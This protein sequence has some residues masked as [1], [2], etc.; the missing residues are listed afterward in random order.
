MLTII[1]SSPKEILE[2]YMAPGIVELNPTLNLNL[3]EPETGYESKKKMSNSIISSHNFIGYI[4]FLSFALVL[5]CF[6]SP[7]ATISR[8]L[9]QMMCSISHRSIGF[10]LEGSTVDAILGGK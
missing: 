6:P 7:N 9:T 5:H 10:A 2:R 8:W 1:G 4:Y 3:F